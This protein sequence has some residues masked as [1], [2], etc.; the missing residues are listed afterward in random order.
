MTRLCGGEPGLD[1]T[2]VIRK[3]YDLPTQGLIIYPE[4]YTIF[5]INSKKERKLF[6]V[7]DS[8]KI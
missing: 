2:T 4:F 1:I 6:E 5:G 7:S 3:K 8:G